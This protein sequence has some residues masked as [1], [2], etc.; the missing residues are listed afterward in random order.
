MITA[1]L[2]SSYWYLKGFDIVG[3]SNYMDWFNFMS[4]DIHGIWDSSSEW[5]NS[6]VNLHTNLT[7]A[8][9][10]ALFGTFRNNINP[11]KVALGLGF[12]GRS[13]TLKD[14]SCNTPGCAFANDIGLEGNTGRAN[15]RTCTGT[16][17]I[18]SNYEIVRILNKSSPQVVYDATAGV[19]WT[20]WN[21]NQWVLYDNAKTLLQKRDFAN[22]QC[23]SGTFA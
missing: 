16:S 2:P 5:T 22:A 18:L 14:A 12:Y 3:I 17:N 10:L 19:N 21:D 11:A 8:H 7:G 9:S 23:L 13:F 15:P 4:Y 6:V 20:T 1:T